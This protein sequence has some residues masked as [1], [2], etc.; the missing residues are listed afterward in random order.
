MKVLPE[1]VGREVF[2]PVDYL[3]L[4]LLKGKAAFKTKQGAKGTL[5]SVKKVKEKNLPVQYQLHVRF[6][7]KDFWSGAEDV[8]DFDVYIDAEE[9]EGKMLGLAAAGIHARLKVKE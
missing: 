3:I 6:E 7:G 1:R 4:R 8:I 2:L 9:F 5:F